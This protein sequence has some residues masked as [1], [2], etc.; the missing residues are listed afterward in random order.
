MKKL[1]KGLTVLVFATCFVFCTVFNTSAAKYI[2]NVIDYD[3]AETSGAFL[4]PGDYDGNG[5]IEE[6]DAASLRKAIL[7]SEI[8][9][10]YDTVFEKDSDAVYSD[11]N[12]DGTVDIRDLVLQDENKSAK[13]VADGVMILNG[14]SAY[15]DGLFENLG[16]GA[17]YQ[18]KY[19]YN[20][21]DN[22]V[23]R[24]NG[25]DNLLKDETNSQTEADVVTV[26]RNI[27]TPFTIDEQTGIELQIIGEGEIKDFSFTR[28]NMDNVIA[29]KTTW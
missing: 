9:N 17:E 2:Q 23:V 11:V 7:T 20:E 13:L 15:G 27:K 1:C 29:D 8:D 24:L 4:A 10:T 5:K 22:V 12:G 25:L 26:T 3:F 16:T 14:N 6:T 28:I 21:G 19:S 18:I